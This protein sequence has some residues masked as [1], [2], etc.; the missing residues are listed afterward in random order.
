LQAE[1]DKQKPAPVTFSPEEDLTLYDFDT[2]S[3]TIFQID[4]S[5]PKSFAVIRYCSWF[6]IPLTP[7][8]QA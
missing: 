1:A 3:Y 2:W 4:D 7:P 6:D 5:Q 8:P